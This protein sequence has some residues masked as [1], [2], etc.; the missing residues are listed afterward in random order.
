M[1]PVVPVPLADLLLARLFTALVSPG[2]CQLGEPVRVWLQQAVLKS[3]IE[4][5]P[6]DE[7]LG[8]AGG[9]A[10][11]LRRRLLTLRRDLHLGHALAL[12]A[13][14]SDVSEWARCKR[15]APLVAR[16]EADTW[17]RAARWVEPSSAWPAWKAQLFHAAKTGLPLPCT[18]RGLSEAAKRVV[19]YSLPSERDRMLALWI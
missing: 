13:I 7:A 18:A 1:L 19:P 14:D 9:G 5:V 3:A 16:F 17:P 12:V 6:L 15:L 11:T 2:K 10:R 8:L 4:G